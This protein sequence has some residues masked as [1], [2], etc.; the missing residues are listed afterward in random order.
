M[1][2]M[3]HC[4]VSIAKYTVRRIYTPVMWGVSYT[5]GMLPVMCLGSSEG[6]LCVHSS[7]LSSYLIPMYAD[8][9]I[10]PPSSTL[11]LPACTQTSAHSTW[12]TKTYRHVQVQW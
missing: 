2:A 12:P 8:G 6:V 9:F 4:L 11:V 7:T 1:D 10:I 3:W 5:A